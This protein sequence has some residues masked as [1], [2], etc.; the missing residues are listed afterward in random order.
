ML[1]PHQVWLYPS[2]EAETRG[3][4][5][6]MNGEFTVKVRQTGRGER[7]RGEALRVKVRLSFDVGCQPVRRRA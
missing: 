2:L 1:G 6:A 5:A 4:A 3:W 7:S